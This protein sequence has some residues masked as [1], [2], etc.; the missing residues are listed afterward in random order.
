METKNPLW[1][2]AAGCVPDAMP[3]DIPRIAKA[4]GFKSSGMWVERATTW[5]DQALAKTK[6]ALAE[7]DIQLIDCEVVW[8]EGDARATDDQKLV[9]EVGLELGAR[10]VLVV[11]RHDDL[12]ASKQQFAELCDIAGDDIRVCLEFG[13]FTSIKNLKDAQSFVSDV[14]HRAAGILV[15]MMHLNRAG[16]DLPD[17][18]ASLYPY[19]QA[20]D[21][22]A[23]SGSLEGMDYIIAAVDERYCLGEA[24]AS[25]EYLTTICDAPVDVSLEIR[26][27]ALRETYPDPF[28]RGREIFAR[29]ARQRY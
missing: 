29:C 7:T 8:L 15:D 13:E 25:H 23:A 3:W 19:V 16:D 2:L 22:M 24:E 14:D 20:C 5:D 12:A 11:S 21:F 9:V 28:E 18:N 1:A 27:K 6:V 10:N 17:I 4:A 26:S